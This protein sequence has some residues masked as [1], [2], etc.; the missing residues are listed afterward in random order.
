M[1]WCS[2][3]VKLDCC[4]GIGPCEKQKTK[5]PL[6]AA[7]ETGN[8]NREAAFFLVASAIGITFG[9]L[10]SCPPNLLEKSHVTATVAVARLATFQEPHVTYFG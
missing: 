5:A 8:P 9:C 10:H 2:S 6:K 7:S 4:A 1:D 3:N